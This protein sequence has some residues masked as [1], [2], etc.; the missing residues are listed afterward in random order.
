M[1]AHLDP[2]FK[3]TRRGIFVKIQGIFTITEN[4]TKKKTTRIMHSST[5]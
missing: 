2:P 1:L 5:V 4:G 3:P